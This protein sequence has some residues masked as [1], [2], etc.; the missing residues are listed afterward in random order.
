LQKELEE[1]EKNEK[2]LQEQ[3]ELE[4]QAREMKKK[5]LDDK[6]A[7]DR[8]AREAKIAELKA[9]KLKQEEEKRLK[10]EALKAGK[11]K[12]LDPSASIATTVGSIDTTMANKPVVSLDDDNIVDI[13][14]NVNNPYT[15]QT[16][17]DKERIFLRLI[18]DNINTNQSTRLHAV[19]GKGTNVTPVLEWKD[20]L[21]LIVIKPEYQSV[22][23]APRRKELFLLF[24]S[25]DGY[26]IDTHLSVEEE[27]RISEQIR[28]NS[29]LSDFP[30]TTS[31]NTHIITVNNDK[32]MGQNDYGCD[33][34]CVQYVKKFESNCYKNTQIPKFPWLIDSLYY[35]YHH[36]HNQTNNPKPCVFCQ[37][38]A[39]MNRQLLSGTLVLPQ[40]NTIPTKQRLLPHTL[41]QS[42]SLLCPFHQFVETQ[43]TQN[44]SK[45]SPLSVDTLTQFLLTTTLT[46]KLPT[47][48][49]SLELQISYQRQVKTFI[50]SLTFSSLINLFINFSGL[51]FTPSELQLFHIIGDKHPRRISSQL[52]ASFSSPLKT[53]G[54]VHLSTTPNQKQYY[55]NSIFGR[56]LITVDTST[57]YI[58][59]Q[60]R[61][62]QYDSNRWT[63][64][65]SSGDY[66]ALLSATCPTQWGQIAH[67]NEQLNESQ[68]DVLT[69]LAMN[70]MFNVMASLLK[71]QKQFLFMKNTIFNSPNDV[72][73]M[74]NQDPF[75]V[76]LDSLSQNDA[77][78]KEIVF[79]TFFSSKKS[80]DLNFCQFCQFCSSHQNTTNPDQ[81]TPNS[82]SNVLNFFPPILIQLILKSAQSRVDLSS[83]RVQHEV[84]SIILSHPFFSSL[85]DSL[86]PD[87]SLDMFLSS[88]A[89]QPYLPGTNTDNNDS[90]GNN[91]SSQNVLNNPA[92][93]SLT[94][95]TLSTGK[96]LMS[97]V[98][99]YIIPFVQAKLSYLIESIALIR[100]A[101]SNSITRE[102]RIKSIIHEKLLK[103][104][105][106]S[107]NRQESIN[108][109][110]K[111]DPKNSIGVK[112]ALIDDYDD[113]TQ[114][115]ASIVSKTNNIRTNVS[116]SDTFAMNILDGIIEET[117]EQLIQ[118]TK[119][120]AN[121]VSDKFLTNYTKDG[122]PGQITTDGINHVIEYAKEL[123]GLNYEHYVKLEQMHDECCENF[124]DG[125]A[126]NNKPTQAKSSTI[127]STSQLP[128]LSK[129]IS[130]ID[131]H[132]HHPHRLFQP[133]PH[134]G[135]ANIWDNTSSNPPFALPDVLSQCNPFS[136]PTWLPSSLKHRTSSLYTIGSSFHN[137]QIDMRSEDDKMIDF[138]SQELFCLPPFIPLSF[139]LFPPTINISKNSTFSQFSQ[140]NLR[141]DPINNTNSFSNL[142][143][144]LNYLKYPHKF[145]TMPSTQDNNIH[146]IDPFLVD[147]LNNGPTC[148]YYCTC[149]KPFCTP[150]NTTQNC[151]KNNSFTIPNSLCLF[152]FISGFLT[153][154]FSDFVSQYQAV[155]AFTDCASSPTADNKSDHFM[156]DD[157][158]AGIEHDKSPTLYPPIEYT[159]PDSTFTITPS[160]ILLDVQAGL[161][162]DDDKF[163]HFFNKN[164][165]QCMSVQPNIYLDDTLSTSYDHYY[166]SLKQLTQKQNYTNQQPQLNNQINK[167]ENKFDFSKIWSFISITTLI[168][169]LIEFT[170][171]VM[172][173][174]VKDEQETDTVKEIFDKVFNKIISSQTAQLNQFL[175]IQTPSTLNKSSQNMAEDPKIMKLPTELPF[176]T[177]N[178][179]TLFVEIHNQVL[180][181][182]D[183]LIGDTIL[184]STQQLPPSDMI[185][186]SHEAVPAPPPLVSTRA[187]KLLGSKD[188]TQ[189]LFFYHCI[190]HEIAMIRSQQV[191][192]AEKNSV[193]SFLKQCNNHISV[194]YLVARLK[195]LQNDPSKVVNGKVIVSMDQIFDLGTAVK[196]L[197]TPLP[198]PPLCTCG[199]K[200]DGNIAKCGVDCLAGYSLHSRELLFGRFMYGVLEQVAKL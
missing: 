71:I 198:S 183:L 10:I 42:G 7:R 15:S 62:R 148:S 111:N 86:S 96:K 143:M 176:K 20:I 182:R 67:D 33:D 52:P 28:I 21:P 153:F 185:L 124:C 102:E 74:P 25:N 130:P 135:H 160:K 117:L 59:N 31:D 78:Y 168:S 150:P 157:Q 115:T 191:L 197:N 47:I 169:P 24:T 75:Q 6:T 19:L 98:L 149:L 140:S 159:T 179:L 40:N 181:Q 89:G 125:K 26:N 8:Q 145:I 126:L 156:Q 27:K 151:D 17:T 158:I 122:L 51:S 16:E 50:T 73:N 45:Q 87:F 93:N 32:S 128:S 147:L 133:L 165:N 60:D 194:S 49:T 23:L 108:N 164:S 79:D 172:N 114:S 106:T 92:N 64:V 154:S 80:Q 173:T 94:L 72:E 54:N 187:I 44:D 2:K 14:A 107:K 63:T 193:I 190:K 36:N 104:E 5:E 170:L 34:S 68:H 109:E 35:K 61:S 29:Q 138:Y 146:S 174:I 66:E 141:N 166:L 171:D 30:F 97:Q 100:E 180:E 77:H 101:L 39:V 81:T 110:A 82:S 53:P 188:L 76:I 9:N 196:Q 70:P 11:L 3:I 55:V 123:Y 69:P 195:T 189:K 132:F 99:Q 120:K 48:F 144:T 103:I 37:I 43:N 119:I 162:G 4:K 12:K 200:K 178:F 22:T 41:T 155:N 137:H 84:T 90:K 95:P 88:P 113:D 91:P 38:M 177:Y 129:Y 134:Q 163:G 121:Q 184:T 57:D 46:P 58:N 18:R 1:R 161:K 131:N 56:R 152:Q 136:Q 139:L 112:T 199:S 118:H 192:L 127:I 83:V 186:T 142:P 85:A 105:Q 167:F 65:I 116:S 13:S 175:S